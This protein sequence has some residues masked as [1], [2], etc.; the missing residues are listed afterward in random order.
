[1]VI[2]SVATLHAKLS[3]TVYC[4]LSCLWVCVC[5]FLCGWV[6]YCNKSKLHALIFTKLGL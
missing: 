3:S 6:C 5:V 2:A 4:N 1:M